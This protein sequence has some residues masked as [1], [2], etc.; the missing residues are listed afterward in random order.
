MVAMNGAGELNVLALWNFIRPFPVRR[1]YLNE[2]FSLKNV[3]GCVEKNYD[4]YRL[5][6]GIPRSLIYVENTLACACWPND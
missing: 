1:A 4:F 6:N 5:D 3:T 2:A